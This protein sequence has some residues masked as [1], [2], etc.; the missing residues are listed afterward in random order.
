MK[1]KL[2]SALTN[3]DQRLIEEAAEAS[4]LTRSIPARLKF[5]LPMA[6]AAAAAAVCIFAVNNSGNR[7]VDLIEQPADSSAVYS[8]ILPANA[9]ESPKDTSVSA[10]YPESMPLIVPGNPT[11]ALVMDSEKPQILYAD[12]NTVLFTA[13][14]RNIYRYDFREGKITWNADAY[15]TLKNEIGQAAIKFQKGNIS[16]GAMT[17]GTPIVRYK[18]ENGAV[19]YKTNSSGDSLERIDGDYE[20]FQPE[21]FSGDVLVKENTIFTDEY[22]RL[23]DGNCIT[24]TNSD[25][26]IYDDGENGLCTVTLSEFTLDGSEVNFTR[27]I[28]PFT[29]EYLESIPELGVTSYRYCGA[30]FDFD[31]ENRTFELWT[32]GFVDFTPCGRYAVSGNT[33]ALIFDD[34]SRYT[35]TF[36]DSN[37]NTGILFSFSEGDPIFT[38]IYLASGSIKEDTGELTEMLFLTSSGQALNSETTSETLEIITAAGFD[39]YLEEYIAGRME[40]FGEE[41]DKEAAD[42][43]KQDSAQPLDTEYWKPCGPKDLEPRSLIHK[44]ADYWSTSADSTEIVGAD[45]Y[46]YQAG[47]VILALDSAGE[48]SIGNYVVIDHGNGLATV[49]A[50][51]GEVLVSEGQSVEKGEV[52]AKTGISGWSTGEHLHFEIRENGKLAAPDEPES[53]TDVPGFSGSLIWPVGGDGGKISELMEN[54]GG[55]SGH[56][57]IDISAPLGTPVYAAAPGKVISL[58]YREGLGFCAVIDHGGLLTLYGH[59]DNISVTE[60]QQVSAGD[61][62]AEAGTTGYTTYA[63]LH[64]EV[65]S[66]SSE[67]G[68]RLDPAEL[69]PNHPTEF[70][71]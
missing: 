19:C 58:D 23:N 59:I 10:D 27:H 12:E 36:F 35:G 61:T 18:L 22:I 49:Y 24:V 37:G 46:S 44:G 1:E 56:T 50:S 21:K 63:A 30:Y 39:S 11:H 47:T 54:H 70:I 26:T 7:G 13:L 20:L 67:D 69:L 14:G 3:M 2:N 53:E 45:V 9:S 4:R 5:A 38:Q 8:D 51:L 32:P 42:L 17:D 28:Q 71:S 48:N 33:V 25:P 68:E 55:Y 60:G 65:I 64:F 52:I 15:A 62:I 66:G 43:L 34:G 31:W 41:Y 16:F 57:G 6:G 40:T 29:Q